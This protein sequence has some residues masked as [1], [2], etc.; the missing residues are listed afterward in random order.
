MWA[1][2]TPFFVCFVF[3]SL[4]FRATLAAYG[5][6][7]ARGPTGTVAASLDQS[8]HNAGSLTHSVRP[9]I[10]PTSSWILVGF[11]NY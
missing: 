3:A 1:L 6:S 4:F 5:G 11:I 7:Q 2:F 8:H 10:Q 9:G